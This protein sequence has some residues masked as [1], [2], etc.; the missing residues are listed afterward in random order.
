MA[1]GHRAEAL[2]WFQQIAD[3]G[4][5]HVSWPLPYVR[6]FYFLGKIH[7]SQGEVGKARE[8]FQRFVDFWKDGDLDRERVAEARSSSFSS[9]A[10]AL[11][12][13]E[14][15]RGIDPGRAPGGQEA[16][17]ENGSE[18]HERR[19]RE[20]PRIGLGSFRTMRSR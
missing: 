15:P 13:A 7:E 19:G 18:Q 4:W 17:H 2:A 6:S 1:A 8:N 5:E 16:R 14:G 3:S 10:E 20:R 9:P 11:L 12:R